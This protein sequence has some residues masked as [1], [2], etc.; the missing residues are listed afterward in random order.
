MKSC[1]FFLV[2]P[3]NTGRITGM[4]GS[5]VRGVDLTNMAEVMDAVGKDGVVQLIHMAVQYHKMPQLRELLSLGANVDARDE[6][7]R[8]PLFTAA[9]LGDIDTMTVLLEHNA[10]VLAEDLIGR[11]PLHWAVFAKKDVAV[12]LLLDNGASIEAKDEDGCTPLHLAADADDVPTFR[13]LIDRG[14]N[15]FAVDKKGFNTLVRA[16]LGGHMN[17]AEFI[18]T[19]GMEDGHPFHPGF[20]SH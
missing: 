11:T 19:Y 6:G 12:T 3:T 2:R 7:G 20:M 18:A 1:G 9:R 14:A 8:T 5:R 13:F 16:A 10:N 17:I 4:P 15:M